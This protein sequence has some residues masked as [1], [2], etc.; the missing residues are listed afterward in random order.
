MRF[1]AR[2]SRLVPPLLTLIG[3]LLVSGTAQMVSAQVGG[4]AVGEED[5]PISGEPLYGAPAWDPPIG[6]AP[7]FGELVEEGAPI[8]DAIEPQAEW[9]PPIGG[10]PVSG[11]PVEE[12]DV[13]I[14][15]EPRY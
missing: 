8:G 2:V 12:D 13:P 11:E 10:A 4:R 9:D 15:G 5:G 1:D 14:A 7:V 3:F 6:G